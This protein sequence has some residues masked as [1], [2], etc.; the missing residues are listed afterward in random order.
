MAAPFGMRDQFPHHL[1]W[2]RAL[3]RDGEHHFIESS[4]RASET[5]LVGDVEAAAH[6]H[7]GILDRHIVERREPRQLGEQS[8]RC[9]YQEVVERRG[10]A[11]LPTSLR[12]LIAFDAVSANSALEVD[13]FKD[14]RHGP[15][16]DLPRR[17]PAGD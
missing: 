13:I 10:A 16:T 8:E 12:G 4:S 5:Q 11:V 3:D 9:S 7:F 17:R 15:K 14:S 1:S 2:R 6:V